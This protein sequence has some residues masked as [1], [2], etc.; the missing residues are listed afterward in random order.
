VRSE[1]KEKPEENRGEG[2]G[3]RKMPS[4]GE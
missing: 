4:P 1:E 2:V 3:M